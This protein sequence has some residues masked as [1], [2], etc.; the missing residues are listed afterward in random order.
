MFEDF[1]TLAYRQYNTS[2]Q[3]A[4]TATTLADFHS[5]A[6][7]LRRLIQLHFPPDRKARILDLGCGHG[8]L[9]YFASQLGY[10]DLKGI[11]ASHEQVETA[12]RLGVM[13]VEQGDAFGMLQRMPSGSVDCLATIDVIEHLTREESMALALEVLRV[14]KLNGRWIIHV[15]NGESP[16]FGGIRYGD[17]TH[18]M[19]FTGRSIGQMLKLSGF[20]S[21][22]SF[23]DTP[24]V[25]GFKS[26]VRYLIWRLVRA[27]YV[28]ALTAEAGSASGRFF[29]RNFLTVAR[30]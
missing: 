28:I 19:A 7:Y 10:T 3:A 17:I 30:K 9:L 11:D 18:E 14:L 16:F 1:R 24:V 5:Q 2:R 27:T 22:S 4:Q 15:P 6:P 21:V 26:A 29:T 23:E 20:S 12:R 25:H 13:C 8:G